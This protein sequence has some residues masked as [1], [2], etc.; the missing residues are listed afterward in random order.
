MDMIKLRQEYTKSFTVT[1]QMIFGFAE[2]T[3]D[4]N[5]VHID[6]A[7]ASKTFFKKRIAHGFLV[8]SFISAVLGNDFPGNGTIYL[9]QTM[10]F[11]RPV[12]IGDV[13][14]VHIV[15]KKFLKKNRIN[16]IT[17]CVNQAGEEVIDGEAIIIPPHMIKLSEK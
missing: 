5:P 6:E 8:G 12:Y 4:K 10:S 9:S 13:I 3:G 15:V 14:T 11:K 2:Y 7:Y 17:K 1:E 16:L